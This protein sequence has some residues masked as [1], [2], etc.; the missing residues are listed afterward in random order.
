MMVRTPYNGRMARWT[1]VIALTAILTLVSCSSR[2][3]AEAPAAGATMPPASAEAQLTPDIAAPGED[4]PAQ[5]PV[6]APV[7]APS[8]TSAPSV[9]PAPSVSSVPPPAPSPSPAATAAPP[10][11]PKAA[12]VDLELLIGGLTKPLFA[13]PA[14]GDGGELYILEQA[15]RVLEWSGDGEPRIWLDIR[16]QV[17]SR[18]SEQGLL[19]MAFIPGEADQARFVLDYTDLQ[20]DTVISRWRVQ[21]DAETPAA[22]AGSE[23]LL[24]RIDQPAANHN[25]GML[26]FGPDGYLYVGMGDGGGANDAY[27]NGQNP[28]GLLGKLLRIDTSTPDGQGY[29]VPPDNPWVG[30]DWGGRPVAD[31]VWAVGLRN[32]WRFSFDRLTGDLWLSDV[33]QNRYE[34]INF[35]PFPLAAGQNFGW[36]IAEG[37]HCFG[38]GSCDLSG[39]VAPIAEYDHSAGNCSITG[40]YVYRGQE[41]PELV[42]AY[43]YGDYCSGGI[44]ALW[45]DPAGDW[46][47]RL[48]LDT[49]LFIS[50]FA[51]DG[52]GELL[53]LDLGGGLY[54]LVRG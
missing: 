52:A 44:W 11:D 8:A 7:Q 10:A 48:L 35:L 33:G 14:P 36:P 27:R 49:D 3:A 5:A 9:S 31:E 22:D 47:T 54:R 34:E 6:Q 50:S 16:A 20:G 19:G 43:I 4:A 15:G 30:Q 39:L 38:A 25:G 18:G 29:R 53:V 46:Q 28:S 51:E 32:P 21:T 41:I 26:A 37:M 1:G 13:L 24:L 23:E 12:R 2:P 42:G 45:R 17:T 40:G